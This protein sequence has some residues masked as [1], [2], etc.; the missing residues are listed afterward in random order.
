MQTSPSFFANPNLILDLDSLSLPWINQ[1][2][3]SA[4]GTVFGR[5]TNV[6]ANGSFVL[7]GKTIHLN[8]DGTTTLHGN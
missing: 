5:V 6:I 1:H 8:K 3:S 2:A 7:D 4:L